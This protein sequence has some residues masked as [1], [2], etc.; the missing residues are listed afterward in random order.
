MNAKKGYY[1]L[2]Q[3]CP[4][5]SRLE[6]VNVGVLLLCPDLRFI[7]A[8][9]AK[10]NQRA[11]NLVG[12]AF[13]DKHSLNRAKRAIERR[14][15]TDREAFSSV[16]DLQKFV[17]SRGNVLKLTPPRPVK[18]FDPIKDLD[19]LFS[20][21]V[22]GVP[23]RAQPELAIPALDARF[24]QLH[25]QGRAKL[26]WEVTVP[27]V[28]RTLRV[29]YAYRNGMWNLVKP[30]R[31]SC[32]EGPALGAAMR[33]AIEGDLLFKHKSI[34]DGKKQL[35]V[36]SSFENDDKVERLRDR[37]Q[38]VLR[39]Y[40]VATVIETQVNAFLSKVEQEAHPV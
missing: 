35:I 28:G 1:S 33:L 14:V 39:E 3:F 12:R 29:P 26:N 5:A 40:H 11:A 25:E 32:Q 27:V 23:R 17:D 15:Q 16:D 10:G 20:E 7:E 38:E 19:K 8:R 6:A 13:L 2:I 9:T 18:V 31:F 36:V 22:G 24:Q 37:V 34:D 4:N 21:L 30:Q